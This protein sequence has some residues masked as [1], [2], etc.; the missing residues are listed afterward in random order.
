MTIKL[1]KEQ[2]KELM[3]AYNAYWDSYITG[4]VETMILLLDDD[5][6]QIGSAETEVFFNKKD[7]VKFLYETIDQVAGKSEIRNRII[8]IEPLEGFILINDLFDIYVLIES[9]W[10][11]YSKFRA[12]T[13]MQKKEDGWKFIHQHS[14][15]P[16]TRTREG[17]NIAIEK[18]SAENLQL[19]EAVKRRTIELEQKN[20]ELE[21]ETS[22]ERVRA[23]AMGMI[24]SDDLMDI[25][26]A[27]LTELNTLG[28]DNIRN[29]QIDILNDDKG[30]FLNYEYSDYGVSGVTE[31][32]YDSH[33]IVE[34]FVKDVRSKSNALAFSK[35]TG[36]ELDEWRAY[37]KQSNHLP[38]PKLDEATS[39]YYYCYSIGTGAL[40]V[41]SFK[42]IDDQK[43]EILIRFRNV[44]ELAYRRYSDIT[45]AES[46]AMEA[47]IEASLE[48]VRAVAMSMNKSDDLL[49][50][51][52]ISFKEF[53]KLGFDNLRNRIIHILNDEKGF[54]LDYDYSDYLGGSINNIRYNSHPIVENY[55][56]QIK[57]ADDAFAEVVIE[58]DQ[59]DS[60]K[61]F[62][63]RGGQPDDP[64]LDDIQALY[65]YL[66]SI[67]VGDI[68]ISTFNPIDE[69]Q[70]KILKR[71]RNVF[72]LAYRTYTD[73]TKAEAQ[74][75]E[76]QIQ[77]ALERVRARTMA[78]HKSEELSETAEVLFEQLNLLGKIPDRMSIGIINE[79]TKKVEFWVTDQGGNQL[80]HEFFF[81]L[82]E[83]TC[84]A[85]IYNA[86]KQESDSIIV[87]LTGQ[88]LQDWLQFVKENAKLPIDETKIK[89]R[90]IQ[91][92]A[93]FSQGFLFLTTHEPVA[94]EIMHLLVRF[95]KV[96]DQTYRR[97][98]D[99]Q[100]A[101]AQARE[102]QIETALERVRAR[103]MA[104]QQSDEL[105]DTASVLFKQFVTLGLL[106]KRC[107][108][109]IIDRDT[110][111]AKMWVTSTDGKVLP[112]VDLVPLTEEEHLIELYKTWQNK[113]AIY[114]FSVKGEDR[115]KWTRYITEKVKMNLPEYQ[116]DT[117]DTD[118]ILNEPAFLNSFIFSHGFIMLHTVES[119]SENDLPVLM[120]FAS[121]FEQTYTRFLDLQNAEAQAR[122][123]KIEV[124]LER[125]RSR[126]MAMHDSNELLEAVAVFFQPFKSLGLLPSE[127]R[128]YF[129]HINTD[130][131]TAKVWMTHTDGKVM[132]G[133]HITPL[134]KSPSM[135]KYYEAWKSKEPLNIRNYSGKALADYM[136]FLSTLRH[137]AEDE[138][139]QH[140][141]K[142]P[143]ERIVMTD[144]NFL[145]GNIGVM[146]V[147][148]LSQEALDTLV[149]FAKVFE[150]TYTRFLDLE[151]A[152]AQAREAK[153]ETALEKVR[154][155]AMSMHSS[156]DLAQTVDTF[157]S[158]LNALNVTPHR[159]G[160]GIIDEESRIVDISANT[161]THTNKIEKVTGKLKLSGH[162]VLNSIFENWKLQ[163]EYHPVLR[164]KE[165][166]DYYKVMN[167]QITFPDFAGDETQYGYYFYFKEGGVFAWTD[168]EF[169][170][171]DLQ[172]FRRYTSVLSLTYRRYMDLKEA[173]AQAREAQIEAALERVRSKAMAMQKS[174][175]LSIAVATIFDE[176]DKLKLG[177]LRCGIGILN[178]EK[179]TA[180]VWTTTIS[181]QGKTVQVSGDESMDIHPLLQGAF[182]AWLEQTDFSLVLEGEELKK[183][184]KALLGVNFKL[185]DSE[186]KISETEGLKQYYYVAQFSG[187]WFVC[188][189]ETAFRMNQNCNETIRGCIYIYLYT[190]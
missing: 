5:Y 19:R 106:P 8:K 135:L 175:D 66:Y 164:G 98:L 151:K 161:T 48:R 139:Y 133:S 185:P 145:Q 128:T 18:I 31:V 11:F 126:T 155:K 189:Q 46:Q 159:C 21:I 140:I 183:Y 64:K 187:W 103:T 123:A 47:Q 75:R 184:Y 142:D 131:H 97:F 3:L 58:G 53:Q 134:N 81:S 59:L 146:T 170:E 38:D 90:R 125:V 15:M 41:S 104:M 51:C 23:I 88:N 127:A 149:R 60:W 156:E 113:K 108:I 61:D 93:F 25:S 62:R 112:G 174:D 105:A 190:F 32:F 109:G 136:Q 167:P 178:K 86:W 152:E 119:L 16:D 162:P 65:Y 147:E 186:S 153:I 14:S 163:K 39:L 12:S 28:F 67:G 79:K 54:F 157:F 1:S 95:A 179:R 26:K 83:P 50:I 180:D 150:L 132:E 169:A 171:G 158:E 72:D 37:R 117:I 154:A 69:S 188:F 144:A 111:G 110:H 181:E 120:R 13:L 4:D 94:S 57:R 165:I 138:G 52:E 172:I 29:T 78:M 42:P 70:I 85:K 40:G 2:E 121:V 114:S 7:A 118:Q 182:N 116:P 20:R 6:N 100:I 130:I 76:S 82:D 89:G 101:E 36:P 148:P 166:L 55:L 122:E 9:E 22:L 96:F 115:L 84:I 33:P 137:V 80:S 74:A 91:Q 63:R 129:C 43:L 56:K 160:V 176:L 68:G 87:D 73:I 168:Q 124:A 27:L 24:K 141:F 99:L 173:E 49:S 10:T 177:M 35:V 44:F 92:A 30:S 71:F 77:L 143:P 17:E 45:K 34:Q 102:A 107:S